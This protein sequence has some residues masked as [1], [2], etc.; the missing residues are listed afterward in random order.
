MV[1]NECKKRDSRLEFLRVV[2]AFLILAHH[3]IQHGGTELNSLIQSEFS[4]NQFWSTLIGSWGQLG[5]T[6]FVII[7][8]W[9]LTDNRGG[10][11]SE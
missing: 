7:S 8:S 9:F 3:A 2:A 5:V 11:A 10:I 6:I 1:N 4:I